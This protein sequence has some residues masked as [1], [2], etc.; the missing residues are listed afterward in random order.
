MANLQ[1]RSI[2]HTSQPCSTRKISTLS[3]LLVTDSCAKT[4][5]DPYP[6]GRNTRSKQLVSLLLSISAG[7][8]TSLTISRLGLCNIHGP[9]L[10]TTGGL[11]VAPTVPPAQHTT[12]TPSVNWLNT[13]NPS[14]G[15]HLVFSHSR[16][17][18]VSSKYLVCSCGFTLLYNIPQ[19]FCHSTHGS[20]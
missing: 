4:I 6:N 5:Y 16:P 17:N 12:A 19:T 1:T 20:K 10:S 3:R 2:D 11:T 9:S 8:R 13:R 15:R 18:P 7:Y 14:L